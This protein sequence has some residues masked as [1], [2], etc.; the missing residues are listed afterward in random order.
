MLLPFLT[1]EHKHGDYYKSKH[2]CPSN[3]VNAVVI[4]L[5]DTSSIVNVPPLILAALLE[6]NA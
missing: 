1:G 4:E 2:D 3:H 6:P 5:G